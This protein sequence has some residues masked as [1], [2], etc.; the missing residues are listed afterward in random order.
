MRVIDIENVTVELGGKTVV[1]GVTLGVDEEDVIGLVGESGCGKTALLHAAYGVEGYEPVSGDVIYHVKICTNERCNEAHIPSHEGGCRKC[2][3]PVEAKDVN[4][5]KPENESD[6]LAVKNR[7][8][9]M[10]QRSFSLYSMRSTF[11]NIVDALVTIRYP[12]ELRRERAMELINLVGLAHRTTHIARDLSGGEKQRLV[13]IRQ[14]AMEPIV[15]FLDEPSGTL[16]PITAEYIYGVLGKLVKET[17]VTVLLASHLP[18]FTGLAVQTLGLMEAGKILQVGEPAEIAERFMAKVPPKYESKVT[19]GDPIIEIRDL[20]KYYYTVDRGIIKA[21]DGVNITIRERSIHGLL[22]FSGSGKTTLVKIM[23]GDPSITGYDGTCRVRANGE[24]IDMHPSNRGGRG[25]AL[26]MMST[27]YQ[28]YDMTAFK[29]VWQE[30]RG[31]LPEL[32]DEEAKERI[33]EVLRLL[34]FDDDHIA[35]MLDR[36]TDALSEGEKQRM[37]VG[38]ALLTKPKIAY[39]DEPSGTLDPIS[40]RK[41][42]NGVLR[43]RDELG[44][45]FVIITHDIDFAADVCDYMDTMELGKVIYSGNEPE[46]AIEAM[47]AASNVKLEQVVDKKTLE[48]WILK[49]SFKYMRKA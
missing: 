4:L 22:G 46:K 30:L 49:T 40:M 12:V 14:I 6:A 47:R 13:L 28:E 44:T 8:S 21:V 38:F 16:D 27:S 36:D 37:L 29:T 9:I 5:W 1:D 45:T 19:I 43:A 39:L 33:Y 18:K 11:E 31:V 7:T 41:L 23:M 20:K 15:L 32:S 17:K 25:K 3:S 2:G 48:E 10:L 42:A 26:A 35:E 24:W 34:E